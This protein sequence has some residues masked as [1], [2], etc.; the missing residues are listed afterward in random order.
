[1]EHGLA[2][3]R[4]PPSA[5]A[6]LPAL[7]LAP[8]LVPLVPHMALC[9][10]LVLLLAAFAVGV[11]YTPLNPTAGY[12][13][14]IEAKRSAAWPSCA[15]RFLSFPSTCDKVDMWNG[16]GANQHWEFISTGDGDNSF[17]I[18]A[19]C[20]KYL[21]YP[22]D[23]ANTKT[24]D[25]WSQAG[26]NQK[27]RF[28]KGDND[29]FDYYI[30]A[31]GRSQCAYRFMSFPGTCTTNSADSVDFWSATGVNQR[32]RLYPVSSTNP[33]VHT[34]GSQFVCP[35]PFVWQPRGSSSYKIQCTGGGLKL[36]TS[37]TLDPQTS[38]FAYE[39]DC[40]GGVPAPWASISFPDSRWA[41][42]N[43]ESPDGQFNYL[44]FSDT[45]S[46]DHDNHRL[47]YVVSKT[48]AKVNAY[49]SYA[50]NYLNLGMAAGGDIDSTVFQD[51]DGKTY[52][53]WKTDDNA[54]GSMTTRIWIQQ[55][56]FANGTVSQVSSPRVL[57]DSSGLWWVDSWVFGGSLVEGPEMV[58][59]NGYYYLFFAAGKFCQDTYTEGVARSTSLFGPYEKMGSPVLSN[60]IVGKA[61]NSA[62][63]LT[64]LVGPG[65]ATIVPYNG[66]W[67]IIWHASIG[68]NCDRYAFISELVFGANGWPYIKL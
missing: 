10:L 22:S 56:S 1:V 62:G 39:G 8:S 44:F 9:T 25:L 2:E 37:S 16:A 20:G 55:L 65:H 58:K 67:R 41:P 42:E 36:G 24:I 15:Y 53:I 6:P 45:Q 47:G 4:P 50:P 66:A 38:S 30:E 27:F 60:G 33:A 3:E 14:T 51:T 5:T 54:V 49:T 61:K 48:G 59:A 26:I 18:K 32:F 19:G 68:E 52:L 12:T 17:Y 29:Q 46:T 64:Q 11:A 43:Y 21:S 57:M 13:Y 23:C 63:Q 31:V 40:L 7:P 34:V 28:V 35:D